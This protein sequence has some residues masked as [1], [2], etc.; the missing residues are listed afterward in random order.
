M[1]SPK[2]ALLVAK[3]HSPDGGVN[4]L[5]RALR[6]P[7]RGTSGT[8]GGGVLLRNPKGV[9][10]IQFYRAQSAASQPSLREAT[11]GCPPL[12]RSPSRRPPLK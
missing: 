6:R 9:Y 8:L 10:T 2:E 1:L 11:L 7:R 4:T 3:Q 5:W 12:L